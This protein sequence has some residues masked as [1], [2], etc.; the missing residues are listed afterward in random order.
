[1][2]CQRLSWNPLCPHYFESAWSIFSKIMSVN[3]CGPK[4]IVPLISNGMISDLNHINYT[5]SSWIDFDKF[6]NVLGVDPRRLKMCFLDQL[7]LAKT[8][9][10]GPVRHCPICLGNGLHFVFFHVALLDECPIHNVPLSNPCDK[11]SMAVYE[12]G[13]HRKVLRVDGVS[14]SDCDVIYRSSCGHIL[15][16]PDRYAWN[17]WYLSRRDERNALL[18]F[19]PLLRWFENLS[20]L[21]ENKSFMVE[22]LSALHITDKSKNDLANRLAIAEKLTTLFPYR[23]NIDHVQRI[24]IVT[25]EDL[26]KKNYSLDWFGLYRIVRRQ[27]YTRFFRSHRK[28]WVQ[29]KNM[30]EFDTKSLDSRFL[31][32]VSLAYAAWRMG[33]EGHSSLVSKQSIRYIS[34]RPSPTLRD[35]EYFSSAEILVWLLSSFYCIWEKIEELSDRQCVYIDRM[36][37]SSSYP[38][39]D[40]ISRSSVEIDKNKYSW[41]IC[42][43]PDILASRSDS[44]CFSRRRQHEQMVSAELLSELCSWDWT[45][46]F[47]E[48][49]HKDCLFRIKKH[50]GIRYRRSYVYIMV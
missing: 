6:G 7:G 14:E 43:D 21:T 49:G 30:M 29:I 10:Y 26:S 45:G 2:T 8:A 25:K 17:Y 3:Y 36:E 13:L 50:D 44:R 46:Q 23:T 39:F 42:P 41:T 11:C 38:K 9:S 24:W 19:P 16:D 47:G 28:C 5:D 22:G 40:S 15:F 20:N 12:K 1:M 48:Y 37:W 27:I 34:R 32:S 31:C 4:E 18:I 33:M 35:G